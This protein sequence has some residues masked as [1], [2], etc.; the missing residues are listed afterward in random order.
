M[1]LWIESQPPLL[2]AILVFGF[3]YL[4]ALV[5]FCAAVL[6]APRRIAGKLGA[7]AP[8]MLT[9]LSVFAALLV[10][11]LA[12]RVWAERDHANAYV[13]Q[14]ARALQH[15]V[16][17]VR[18]LPDDVHVAVHA[19]IRKYV[20]FVET[21]DW[22]AMLQGHASVRQ[23][24]LGL[25][26][27][28]AA[29]ASFAPAGAGQQLVQQR[30]LVAIEQIVEA[31]RNRV[32]LSQ[33]SIEPVQWIVILVLAGLVLVCIAVVHLDSL[34]AAAL[35]LFLFATAVA[36]CL[37]LLMVND[38]PFSAGGFHLLPSTVSEAGLD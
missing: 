1:F 12:S 15:C 27:A 23:S 13:A 36:A 20:R 2:V 8:V 4:A 37:F 17:L 21:E 32:L 35:N 11:F 29:L 38:R 34:P 9:P 10:A 22:P 33:A 5:I 6:I 18:F 19:G 28:V 26:D 24:P 14:E 7:T 31:R 30:A 16:Q 3:C 25:K